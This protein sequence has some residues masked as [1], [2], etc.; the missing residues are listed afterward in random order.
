MLTYENAC[1]YTIENVIYLIFILTMQSHL[2][3]KFPDIL[4]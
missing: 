2:M 1:T 4:Q 3:C